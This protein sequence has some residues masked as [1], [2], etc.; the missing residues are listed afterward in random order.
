MLYITSFAIENSYFCGMGVAFGLLGLLKKDESLHQVSLLYFDLTFI[1]KSLPLL[2]GLIGLLP[3]TD[4]KLQGNK[5]QD[6][7]VLRNNKTIPNDPL[8][9]FL[10]SPRCIL[11]CKANKI[12]HYGIISLFLEFQLSKKE[13]GHKAKGTKLENSRVLYS[14]PSL[15]KWHPPELFS[16]YPN[17]SQKTNRQE[18]IRYNFRNLYKYQY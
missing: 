12:V 16:L 10:M 9:D 5:K 14:Y 4:F 6:I 15:W 1:I 17:L 3:P 7:F 18:I 2:L 8:H 13:Q 11:N